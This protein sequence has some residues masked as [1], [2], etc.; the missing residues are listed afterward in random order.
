[1]KAMVKVGGID[2]AVWNQPSVDVG[3]PGRATGR[4]RI[5]VIA[6][7][8]VVGVG[9]VYPIGAAAFSRKDYGTFAFWNLPSRIGYCGRTYDDG[10]P[11]QGS[12][13]LFAS[14]DSE[15]GAH[16]SRLSWTF[17]GR[18]IYAD[19]AAPSP[20]RMTVCTMV[21]YIPL[22]GGTWET[23]SLSGGP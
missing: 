19:T 16:W 22:G 8:V 20:P 4:R 2:D 9:V 21:L 11:E 14:Q 15:T 7:L 10:G 12:A 5:A 1:M 23:Y 3:Q 13:A 18:S 17:S 6:C